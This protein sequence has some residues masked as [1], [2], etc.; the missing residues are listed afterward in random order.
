[1]ERDLIDFP[2]T[3]GYPNS[4]KDNFR[5]SSPMDDL[6]KFFQR[7]LR[8][9]AAVGAIF[10]SL[11]A[12]TA[13]LN[14]SPHGSAWMVKSTIPASSKIT[15]SQV[16][17]IQ[18]NLSSDSAH[19]VGSADQVVGHFTSR[20]LQAGDLITVNDLLSHPGN[21]GA[22]FLPVGIGVNDLPLDLAI[23][24]RVDVYVIPK[25]QAVLPAVV[26]RHLVIQNIDQ[27]SR[28]LGGSVGVSLIVS[29]ITTSL[30][31]TA[32]AQGRLVLARDSF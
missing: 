13:L 17:L 20:A 5:Y 3:C 11:V 26:A 10:I 7:N 12:I 27:K 19:F 9:I 24:D 23:G 14:S 32:E 8:R 1:M 29:S 6:Q 15:S 16:Q 4:L 2:Y 22:S 18:V 28:A 31:V 30:I 25:D 21:N